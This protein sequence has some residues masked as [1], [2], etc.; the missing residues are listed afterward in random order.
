MP[1]PWQGG[2]RCQSG[3]IS[4]RGVR[5]C[6]QVWAGSP[7]KFLRVLSA[8]EQAYIQAS[9]SNYAELANEHRCGF[10]MMRFVQGQGGCGGVRKGL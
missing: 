9:A 8:D 4:V 7:A 2:G 3:L 1:M 5:L 6:S 10:Q